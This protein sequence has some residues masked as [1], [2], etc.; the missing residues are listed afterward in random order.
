MITTRYLAPLAFSMDR[1][2]RGESNSLRR[3]ATTASPS[4]L[5]CEV[6]KTARTSLSG[7]MARPVL[8]RDA[9]S[10]AEVADHPACRWSE[11]APERQAGAALV[12]SAPPS[13]FARKHAFRA[14]ETEG[15][16]VCLAHALPRA[17]E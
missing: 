9:A 3:P 6:K 2:E 8:R 15:D 1:N 11:R 10:A 5:P 17:S 12:K 4:G 14:K 16:D 13:G 7:F